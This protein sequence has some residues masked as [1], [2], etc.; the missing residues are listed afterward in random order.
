MTKEQPKMPTVDLVTAYCK[1]TM[2]SGLRGR[3][4]D[5]KSMERKVQRWKNKSLDYPKKPK[6][7]GDL[8]SLPPQFT[9]TFD[10]DKF[11]LFNKV[12][13]ASSSD[14]PEA[15]TQEAT[16]GASTS[17]KAAG[18]AA[19]KTSRMIGFASNFGLHLLRQAD[20]W[21]ADGTFSVA[22]EPFYQIYTILAHLDG[23]A[24]PAAFV[25]MPGKKAYMYKVRHI[26][27]VII[28]LNSVMSFF[29]NMSLCHDYIDH[30][31]NLTTCI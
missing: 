27:N 21:S 1:D 4:L 9:T 19:G 28:V 15:G 24:F 7:Y 8:E 26:L 14:E 23:Y 12:M 10:G 16:Q 22:P 5:M 6:G 31:G 29:V 13:G 11:L 17:G 20:I 25:F 30:F 2:S 3:A 18:K